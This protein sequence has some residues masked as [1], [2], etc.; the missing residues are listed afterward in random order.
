MIKHNDTE[1]QLSRWG[2]V[3]KGAEVNDPKPKVIVPEFLRPKTLAQQ[4]EQLTRSDAILMRRAIEQMDLDDQDDILE[5]FHDRNAEY[6]QYEFYD[7]MVNDTLENL[8]PGYVKPKPKEKPPEKTPQV[9]VTDLDPPP[10][11]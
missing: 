3:V 7:A 5:M 2:R 10:A 9:P 4:I 1:C 11:G 8:V 6:T